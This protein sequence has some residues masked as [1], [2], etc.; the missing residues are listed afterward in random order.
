MSDQSKSVRIAIPSE[1]PGGLEAR[2]SGHFGRCECFTLVDIADGSVNEV[3]V[4]TNAPHTEGGCMAPVM[5]LAEHMVDAIVVD[6]IGGRPLMGFNQVGIAVHAGVGGDVQTTVGA[7]LEG[8]LPVVGL[9]GACQ[10]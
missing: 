6:G 4:L 5:A 2:R 8:G 3:Q 1:L 9:E 10:H 7:Y